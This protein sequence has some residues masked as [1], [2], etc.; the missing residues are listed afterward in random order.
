M[1]DR[2]GYRRARCRCKLTCPRL[3][4]QQQTTIFGGVRLRRHYSVLEGR[5]PVQWG[6]LEGQ[7]Q[8]LQRCLLQLSAKS[9]RPWQLAHQTLNFHGHQSRQPGQHFTPPGRILIPVEKF[10]VS[11]LPIAE[12][13]KTYIISDFNRI[14]SRRRRATASNIYLLPTTI[15][16]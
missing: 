12:F 10:P 4:N 1:N 3:S 5:G 6:G 13:C 2:L 7:L 8:D 16:V 9:R 15:R 14:L 11:L